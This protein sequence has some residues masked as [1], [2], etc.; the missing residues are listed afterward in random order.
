MSE[1]R[2][3]RIYETLM[4][5]LEEGGQPGIPAVSGRDMITIPVLSGESPRKDLRFR[6]VNQLG[7]GCWAQSLDR[8]SIKIIYDPNWNVLG[9]IEELLELAKPTNASG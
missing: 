7:G 9:K 5:W 2:A 8:D 1:T 6:R 4:R 3:R